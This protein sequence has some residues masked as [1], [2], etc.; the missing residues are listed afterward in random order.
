MRRNFIN[1]KAGKS[2]YINRYYVFTNTIIDGR[3]KTRKFSNLKSL[4]GSLVM[5]M[6]FV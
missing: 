2:L 1:N 3:I 6:S 5:T 4:L